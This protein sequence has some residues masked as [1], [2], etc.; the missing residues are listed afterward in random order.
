MGPGPARSA[1]RG[2]LVVVVVTVVAVAVAVAAVA[3]AA[4]AAVVVVDVDVGVDNDVA[5]ADDVNAVGDDDRK[6]SDH[7]PGA[8]RLVAGFPWP[9]WAPIGPESARK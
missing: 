4:A 5:V 6:H 1:P 8:G 3:V 2:P 9:P 7:R